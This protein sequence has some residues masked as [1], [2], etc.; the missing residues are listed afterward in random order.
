VSAFAFFG[1]VPKRILYDNTT[2][3]V[4]KILGNGQRQQTVGFLALQSHYLFE[5]AFANVARGNEKGGV[6][7]LVGYSRRNFMVPLP[8]FENFEGLNVNGSAIIRH[9]KVVS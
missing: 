9:V 2:I 8:A 7:N 6:E 1:G 4:Q 3:A 5:Q